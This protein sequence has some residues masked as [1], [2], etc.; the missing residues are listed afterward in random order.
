MDHSQEIVQSKAA[1]YFLSGESFCWEVFFC[2]N[3]NE[4]RPRIFLTLLKSLLASGYSSMISLNFLISLLLSFIPA[5]SIISSQILPLNSFLS[6]I[7]P[8]TIFLRVI[9]LKGRLIFLRRQNLP[10]RQRAHYY[11]PLLSCRL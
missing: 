2:L 3:W 10:H 7:R 4:D 6:W 1:H 11:K 9:P 8:L 5:I